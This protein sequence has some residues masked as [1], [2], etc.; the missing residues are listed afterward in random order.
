MITTLFPHQPPASYL[1][2][3]MVQPLNL[4]NSALQPTLSVIKKSLSS[5]TFPAIDLYQSLTR[6]QG[7]WDAVLS[8][9]Y[10]MAHVNTSSDQARDLQT[11]LTTPLST[12]RGLVLRSFPEMLVDIR[13][14]SGGSSTT[15]AI[16]DTTHSTL[17][18]LETLPAYEKTVESLLGRSQSERSWLMGAKDPPSP[19]RNAKDEGGVVNLYVGEWWVRVDA[20]TKR[21]YSGPCSST[22][23]ARRVLCVGQS[24]KLSS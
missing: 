7:K 16:S 18:Y 14:T 12:L 10:S 19:A 3:G 23:T 5:H 4:V 20:H 8:K 22:W 9:C 2:A 13:T 15:S 21:M 24:V 11:A 17:T 1:P 6:T